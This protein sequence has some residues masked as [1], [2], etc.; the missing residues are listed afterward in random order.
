[1][2]SGR[3]KSRASAFGEVEN[4]MGGASAFGEVE[5]GDESV[6]F[7]IRFCRC[8]FI[9]IGSSLLHMGSLK[10]NFPIFR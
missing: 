2:N 7:R 3:F 1:V 10:S 4:G 8:P 5:N 9:N 6:V